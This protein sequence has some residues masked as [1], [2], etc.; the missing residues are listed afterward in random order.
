M[1]MPSDKS[2]TEAKKL[3]AANERWLKDKK[4]TAHKKNMKHPWRKE[5]AEPKPDLEP[6]IK[7]V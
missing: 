6:K 2:Y 1:T 3:Q 4:A 7:G 5:R